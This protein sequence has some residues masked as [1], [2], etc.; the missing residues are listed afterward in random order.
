MTKKFYVFI[1][2]LTLNSCYL[3]KENGIDFEIVN[4]SNVEITNVKFTTSEKLNNIEIEKIVPNEVI[5]EFLSMKYNKTD[6]AYFLE[7]T[8]SNGKKEI[9][10]SGYYTNGGS[11]DRWVK[12]VEEKDTVVVEF[13]GTGY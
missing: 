8:R 3:L 11:L 4:Q 10:K 12:F 5:S 1:L 6:G 2:F 7:F 13:S 9:V